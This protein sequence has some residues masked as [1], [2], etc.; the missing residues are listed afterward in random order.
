MT[1]GL[2]DDGRLSGSETLSSIVE[3]LERRHFLGGVVWAEKS[4]S[5]Q[6]ARSSHNEVPGCDVALIGVCDDEKGTYHAVVS[7]IGLE[8]KGVPTAII[9]TAE[10]LTIAQTV[11]KSLG[12]TA[13]PCIAVD[14][15]GALDDQPTG[16]HRPASTVFDI[17]RA[18]CSDPSYA[19]TDP[20][21]AT[22]RVGGAVR[23]EC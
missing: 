4:G 6:G 16:E 7:A 3:R 11:A 21:S 12:A 1:I 19:L 23:C 5:Q 14:L 10:M 8:A 13:L 17:E 20:V 2:F 9:V 18:L 15:R 22:P